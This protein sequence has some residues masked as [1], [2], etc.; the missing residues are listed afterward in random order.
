[1]CALPGGA[2]AL[3]LLR[4]RRLRAGGAAA[5]RSGAVLRRRDDDRGD[6]PLAGV[7]G[8]R[9]RDQP[10][11][12]RVE[13]ELGAGGAAGAGARP[14]LFAPGLG[15]GPLHRLSRAPGD[16]AWLRARPAGQRSGTP[17]DR[18]VLGALLPPLLPGPEDLAPAQ[19]RGAPVRARSYGGALSGSLALV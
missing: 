14:E 4:H 13:R 11:A 2:A 10:E 18:A 1:L 5:D 3:R 12:P 16:L 7:P 9:V 17:L 6:L 15:L 8:D 19:R